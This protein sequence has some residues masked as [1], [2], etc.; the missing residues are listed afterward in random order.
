MYRD[1]ECNTVWLG[2]GQ[3]ATGTLLLSQFY[4]RMMPRPLEAEFIPRGI[5][6]R[7]IDFNTRDQLTNAQKRARTLASGEVLPPFD[8]GHGCGRWSVPVPLQKLARDQPAIAVLAR[9][10]LN[11]I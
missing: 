1:N 7:P 8:P 6:V 5:V 9:V 2:A 10:L 3:E 11:A 4:Q